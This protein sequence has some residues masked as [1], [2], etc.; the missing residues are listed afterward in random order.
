M[1]LL[2]CGT[3]SLWAGTKHSLASAFPS[4]EDGSCAVT[5]DGSGPKVTGSEAGWVHCGVAGIRSGT[6]ADRLLPD[7]S[8]YSKTYP[9]AFKLPDGSDAPMSFLDASTVDV[10][11]RWMKDYGM[12]VLLCSA[13]SAGT[14]KREGPRRSRVVLEHALAASKSL[15]V[16]LR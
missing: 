5:K 15:V 13:S 1:V 7:V 10:H 4:Y 6:S 14:R 9:T 2:V 11:F 3:V 8:E 16:R 12:T